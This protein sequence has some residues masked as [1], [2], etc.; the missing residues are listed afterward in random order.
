M[1]YTTAMILKGRPQFSNSNLRSDVAHWSGELRCIADQMENIELDFRSL[2]SPILWL[3]EVL[4]ELETI[5]NIHTRKRKNSFD[6][7]EDDC[8]D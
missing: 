4:S 8:Y 7:G 2:D 1:W 5:R 3:Q 6:H